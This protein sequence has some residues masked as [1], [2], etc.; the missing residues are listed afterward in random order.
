MVTA[1]GSPN[2]LTLPGIKSLKPKKKLQAMH[3]YSTKY[4]QSHIRPVF[5]CK[6][7]KLKQARKPFVEV[8]E[9][10]KLIWALWEDENAD[11]RDEIKDKLAQ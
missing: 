6:L 1:K 7:T 5:K 3:A 10:N 2:E 8:V 9:H 11:I 4:Y